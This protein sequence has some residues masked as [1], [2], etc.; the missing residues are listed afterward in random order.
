M[1]D[2]FAICLKQRLLGQDAASGS[3]LIGEELFAAVRAGARAAR[4]GRARHGV[5][6]PA[7][8]PDPQPDHMDD[9]VE[10]T[11][12][13]GGVHINSGIPNRAFHLAAVAIGGTSLE[14]AGRVWYAALTSGD[15]SPRADFAAFAAATVAAAGERADAVRGAW[16]QV[17]VEP[18]GSPGRRP[19]RR[20][21]RRARRPRRARGWCGCV[22]AAAS[23]GGSPRARSTWPGDDPRAAAVA[24]LAGRV[25]LARVARR[26]PMPDMYVYRFEIEGDRRPRSASRC[27]P[28]SPSWRASCSRAAATPAAERPGHG[29]PGCAG[30]QEW[31]ADVGPRLRMCAPGRARRAGSSR[32]Q[33]RTMRGPTG[34]HVRD[35]QPAPFL[36]TCARTDVAAV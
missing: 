13:N 34:S 26:T 16:Q 24:D 2:V 31:D 12:D 8:R 19:G 32:A 35:Y 15:V 30:A 21:G 23:P 17:G 36:R 29:A 18:A 7:A 11:D 5:R 27:R 4:H 28:T 22:A 10:T 25:D 20:R 6:R 9:F 1:S 33:V 14:G 3:W